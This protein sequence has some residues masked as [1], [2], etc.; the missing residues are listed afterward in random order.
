MGE[1]DIELSDGIPEPPDPETHRSYFRILAWTFISLGIGSIPAGYLISN[2]YVQEV[3]NG[4]MYSPSDGF[5]FV[6]LGYV[7]A[8]IFFVLGLSNLKK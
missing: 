5:I 8:I 1:D 6:T 7:F 3:Q 4:I 2:L